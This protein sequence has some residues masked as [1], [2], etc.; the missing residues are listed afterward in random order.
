MSFG[1]ARMINHPE[2]HQKWQIKA[3]QPGQWDVYEL[4]HSKLYTC[5]HVPKIHMGRD[6]DPVST[7]TN[8]CEHLSIFEWRG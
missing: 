1:S 7:L 6:L 3:H 8:T 5:I 4:R 2:I